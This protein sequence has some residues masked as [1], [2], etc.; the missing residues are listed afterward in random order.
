[1]KKGKRIYKTKP[2]PRF[3]DVLRQEEIPEVPDNYRNRLWSVVRVIREV[4][5]T[6]ET[7][8]FISLMSIHF[9][10]SKDDIILHA[11]NLLWREVVET[12]DTERLKL[13][14]EKLE[15]LRLYK[16]MRR[17]EQIRQRAQGKREAMIEWYKENPS[18]KV[19]AYG[20][21]ETWTYRNNRK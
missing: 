16:V 15:G 3:A 11:I 21:S 19:R 8:Y 7:E 5:I 6:E 4:K 2:A 1:M 14:E 13:Y 17:E 18:A 10:I 20:L 9:G 12:I